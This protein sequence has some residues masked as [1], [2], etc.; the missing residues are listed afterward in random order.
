MKNIAIYRTTLDDNLAGKLIWFYWRRHKYSV[1]TGI[2]IASSCMMSRKAAKVEVL[3]NNP[4]PF[5][6]SMDQIYT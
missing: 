4:A 5:I 3:V 2:D 6:I 1:P